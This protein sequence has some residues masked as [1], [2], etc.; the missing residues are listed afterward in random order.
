[1]ERKYAIPFHKRKAKMFSRKKRMNHI[2]PYKFSTIFW[3]LAAP[4]PMP[5]YVSEPFLHVDW[6]SVRFKPVLPNP[7][8]YPVHSCLKDLHPI[9]GNSGRTPFGTLPGYRTSL[10]VV[11]PPSSPVGG[12]VYCPTSE[13]WIVLVK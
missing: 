1:M 3:K 7:E 5:I 10:G 6:N 12:Y 13:K 8:S 11:S 4:E 2:I 9:P